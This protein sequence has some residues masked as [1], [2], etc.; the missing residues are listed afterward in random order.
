MWNLEPSG[1][2]MNVEVVSRNG[3]LQSKGT[4]GL[5]LIGLNGIILILM[6]F[7]ISFFSPLWGSPSGPFFGRVKCDWVMNLI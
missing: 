6:K 7:I 2:V 4:I 3:I 5:R 1:R